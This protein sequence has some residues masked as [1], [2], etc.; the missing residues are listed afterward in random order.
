MTPNGDVE[1]LTFVLTNRKPLQYQK[2]AVIL[3]RYLSLTAVYCHWLE[4]LVH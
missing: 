3:S 2:T 1:V 4:F